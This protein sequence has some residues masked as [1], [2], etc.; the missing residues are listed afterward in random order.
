MSMYHFHS[1]PKRGLEEKVRSPGT[2]V[3][4]DRCELPCG[5]YDLNPS[6]LEEQLVL[7]TDELL[8]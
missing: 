2:G 7:L 6:P 8:L 5:C 4:E 1:V 3:L